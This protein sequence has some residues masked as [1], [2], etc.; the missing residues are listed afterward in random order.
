MPFYKD[1]EGKGYFAKKKQR[2][3][4]IFM[5]YTDNEEPQPVHETK[6]KPEVEE[7]VEGDLDGDGVGYTAEDKSIAGKTLKGKGKKK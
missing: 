5:S 6:P 3:D 1:H 2:D 7:K 4:H